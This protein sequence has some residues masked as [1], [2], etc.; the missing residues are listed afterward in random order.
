MGQKDSFPLSLTR[1]G[2]ARA[3]LIETF[4]TFSKVGWYSEDVLSRP[5]IASGEASAENPLY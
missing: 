2:I 5:W 1:L 3:Q 4:W